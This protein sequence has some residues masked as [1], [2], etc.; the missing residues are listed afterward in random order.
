MALR[1]VWPSWAKCSFRDESWHFWWMRTHFVMKSP[2]DLNDKRSQCHVCTH[3]FS[4]ASEWGQV[5]HS[6]CFCS[7]GEG[8]RLS[9]DFILGLRVKYDSAPLLSFCMMGTLIKSTPIVVFTVKGGVCYQS[10]L[11]LEFEN[12]AEWNKDEGEQ[13]C[14]DGAIQ[15]TV[16][17]FLL[18]RFLVVHWFLNSLSSGCPG[19]SPG[20]NLGIGKLSL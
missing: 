14:S 20:A 3:H 13:M 1:W 18:P 19:W 12:C 9:Y 5:A 6:F 17:S 10:S 8:T 16:S 4:A 11:L 15:M 7:G 2:L